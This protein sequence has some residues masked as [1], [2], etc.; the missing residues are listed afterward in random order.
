MNR[1]IARAALAGDAPLTTTLDRLSSRPELSA[2]QLDLAVTAFVMAVDNTTF[3]PRAAGILG[4]GAALLGFGVVVSALTLAL[5]TFLGLRWLQKPMLAAFLVLGSVTSWFTDSLGVTIDRDMIQNVMTTTFA[6]GH[7]LITP[8]FLLHVAVTGLLPA[9]LVLAVRVRRE[10]LWGGTGR[11]LLRWILPI[12]L[13]LAILLGGFKTY[14]SILRERPE[15]VAVWQPVLPI[16]EGLRYLDFV[17]GTRKIVAAPLGTDA[18]RG[19]LIAAAGKPVVTV[20]V[21]GETARAQ[22]WGLNGYG[23]DTT[24]E[25]ATRGVLNFPH[26]QS[27]GTATAVSM[28]CM[29]SNLG[30][31]GFTQKRALASETLVDVLAHAGVAVEWWDNNTGDKDIAARVVSGRVT[32]DPESCGEGECTDAVFPRLLKARLDAIKGDTVLVFHQIGSHG[33]SYSLRYPRAFERFTPA[34]HT[35]EFANCTPEEIRNAY[36]NSLAYTDHI[37]AELIDQLNADDRVIPALVY[38]SD[39]GESLGENGIYLHGAPW[40]MAPETQTQVP[41]VLWLSDRFRATMQLDAPCLAETA[42]RPAS[43]DNLFHSVLGLMDIR[44]K[45]R[46]ASLDLVSACRHPAS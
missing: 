46:D 12:L 24:P 37:L 3:W 18:V 45:V 36:D 29:F 26:V 42:A 1:T 32:P 9:G 4:P 31:R 28:P 25:L 38:A 34:C 40:L 11:W 35:A 16:T 43:H 7:H 10:S 21:V 41:M 33:P 8:R 44:T 14:S 17:L 30:R 20:F 15:M 22:N 19:P 13:A 27:C 5:A 2:L 39:H 23:V 6:E